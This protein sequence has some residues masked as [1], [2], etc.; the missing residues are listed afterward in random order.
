MAA[1]KGRSKGRKRKTGAESKLQAKPPAKFTSAS[2]PI[3]T[4]VRQVQLWAVETRTIPERTD[5]RPD[6]GGARRRSRRAIQL[7]IGKCGLRDQV[8]PSV[9]AA[10]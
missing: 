8:G 3:R 9:V 4:P 7:I 10:H 2:S 1:T 5:Q 6:C